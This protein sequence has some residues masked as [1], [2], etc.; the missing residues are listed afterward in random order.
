MPGN[1]TREISFYLLG[2]KGNS[3]GLMNLQRSLSH[4]DHPAYRMNASETNSAFKDLNQTLQDKYVLV[5]WGSSKG[6]V[7]AVEKRNMLV[8]NNYGTDTV[9]NKRSFFTVYSRDLYLNLPRAFFNS[10]DASRYMLDQDLSNPDKIFLVERNTLRGHSG[11]G[12]RLIYKD[13]SLNPEAKLWT[14]YVK[15]QREF[16]IHFF[17]GLNDRLIIQQ[18][19]RIRDVPNEEINYQIRHR[20]GGWIYSRQDLNVPVEV[21]NQAIL[22]RN[23][24][25]NHLDFGAVDIIWNSAEQKAY[26]LEVNTAPGIEGE[27]IEE[28]KNAILE[29]ARLHN[30]NQ[31]RSYFNPIRDSN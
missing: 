28:Y 2:Y 22:L 10:E 7:G 31:S 25:V 6:L 18:K 20:Q 27:T 3:R 17:K 21:I 15:K 9:C 8:L 11:E 16:R 4:D 23:S 26:I 24:L 5:N 13:S 19:K 29:Y 14:V 12:I 30:F 1:N